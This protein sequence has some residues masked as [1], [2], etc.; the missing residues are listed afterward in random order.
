MRTVVL[1]LLLLFVASL[2]SAQAITGY[3]VRIYNQG[4]SAPLQ[5][6]T[7]LA[8]VCNQTPPAAPPATVVNPT[9]IWFTD[10]ANAGKACVYSE[11]GSGV[12]SAL[13]F[14]AANYEATV[15]AKNGAGASPES[16]RSNLF[17]RPGSAPGAPTGLQI[18]RLSI[19]G[20]KVFGSRHGRV[21]GEY[22][23]M[24]ALHGLA[25]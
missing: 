7:T 25:R 12:L 13:P 5:G 23:L 17:S 24:P 10:A 15:V 18:A 6:P 16:A 22:H 9:K 1:S 2:A 20:F 11:S 4:A 3:D 8:V 21:G 19:F 14:G